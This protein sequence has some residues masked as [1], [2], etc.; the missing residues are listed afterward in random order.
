M[1]LFFAFVVR[2]LF[3]THFG[4]FSEVSGRIHRFATMWSAVI[5]KFQSLICIYL[6]ALAKC[7]LGRVAK[8]GLGHPLSGRLLALL[9]HRQVT[10]V[11][12]SV[13]LWW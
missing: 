11:G 9:L 6:A 8:C 12:R 13:G 4:G 1:I 5:A 3:G 2:V 7:G 10:D